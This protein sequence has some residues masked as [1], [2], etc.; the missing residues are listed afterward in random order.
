MLDWDGVDTKKLIMRPSYEEAMWVMPNQLIKDQI[1]AS[2][3][4]DDSTLEADADKRKVQD[5]TM[6]ELEKAVITEG[7]KEEK[8]PIAEALTEIITD[9]LG[10]GDH[11]MASAVIDALTSDPALPKPKA[12]VFVN[13]ITR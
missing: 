13:T 12:K 7:T 5:V 3:D 6:V 10:I 11:S 8:N 1:K 9:E 2:A 4:E